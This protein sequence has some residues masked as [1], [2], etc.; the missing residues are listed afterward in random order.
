M[1]ELAYNRGHQQ[2]S[3]HMATN[4]QVQYKQTIS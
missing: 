2:I 3:V 1:S 4:I